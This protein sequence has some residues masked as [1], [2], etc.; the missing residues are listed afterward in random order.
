MGDNGDFS[1]N[2]LHKDQRYVALDKYLTC[3]NCFTIYYKVVT[4]DGN[5]TEYFKRN[6]YHCTFIFN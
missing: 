4:F 1:D 6:G 5:K 2:G 3:D